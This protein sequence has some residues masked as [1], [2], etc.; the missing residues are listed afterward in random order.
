MPSVSQQAFFANIVVR[1]KYSKF[2]QR[3]QH[4]KNH[5]RRLE[6]AR[7]NRAAG[8]FPA[9]TSQAAKCFEPRIVVPFGPPD[10]SRERTLISPLY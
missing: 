2:A 8:A 10:R 3:L 4:A 7:D 9:E 1:L 6:K 5:A